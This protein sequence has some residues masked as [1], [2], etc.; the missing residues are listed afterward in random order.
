MKI[1]D[2]SQ[3]AFE[4]QSLAAFEQR[5]AS[6]VNERVVVHDN[7]PVSEQMKAWIHAQVCRACEHGFDTEQSIATYV[8]TAWIMGDNFDRSFPAA[9]CVLQSGLSPEE[10]A[11]WLGSWAPVVLDRLERE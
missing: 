10:K 5:L 6:F 8:L 9:H 2:R 4:L 1:S 3:I 7:G 11:D